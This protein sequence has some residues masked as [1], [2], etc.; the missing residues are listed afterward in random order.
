MA[1]NTDAAGG[2]VLP[3]NSPVATV[4]GREHIARTPGRGKSRECLNAGVTGSEFTRWGFGAAQEIDS[5]AMS[6][7][8]KYRQHDGELEGGPYAGDLDAFRYISTGAILYF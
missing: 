4:A 3:A 7:W 2:G 1:I 8:I 5:A 6:L